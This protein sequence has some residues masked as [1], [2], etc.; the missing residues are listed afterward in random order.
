MLAKGQSLYFDVI[1]QEISANLFIYLL[2]IFVE[3]LL[4]LKC[5]HVLPV[6]L[7]QMCLSDKLSKFIF[8]TRHHFLHEHVL[9]RREV[10]LIE[11]DFIVICSKRFF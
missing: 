7:Y 11:N 5:K 4:N 9:A 1:H 3:Q 10:Q 8:N 6:T 2:I